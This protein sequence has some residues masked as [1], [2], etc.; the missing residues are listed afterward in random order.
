[1][2]HYKSNFESVAKGF[3]WLKDPSV[4]FSHLC[5]ATGKP[6]IKL[7][8]QRWKRNNNW[9][10]RD[11]DSSLHTKT[12]CVILSRSIPYLFNVDHDCFPDQWVHDINL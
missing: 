10:S 4:V 2:I 6:K 8:R 1:M 9:E 5:F 11:P 3:S 12:S 7:R